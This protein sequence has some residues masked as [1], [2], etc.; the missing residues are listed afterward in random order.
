MTLD[1]LEIGECP[2]CGGNMIEDEFG[3]CVCEICG[4]EEK[5]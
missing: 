5:E 2:L 4:Y 3:I 1:D